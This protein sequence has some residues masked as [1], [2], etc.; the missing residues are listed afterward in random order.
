MMW[1][2]TQQ[3]YGRSCCLSCQGGN[4]VPNVDPQQL[5]IVGLFTGMQ[6]TVRCCASC[7][8]AQGSRWAVSSA[9]PGPGTVQYVV[10][11]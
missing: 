6:A 9:N 5:S 1:S 4:R 3:A 2:R 7:A 10:D 8:R 11:L